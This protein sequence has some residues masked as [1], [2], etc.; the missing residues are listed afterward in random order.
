MSRR[1]YIELKNEHKSVLPPEFQHDDVRF[2]ES[3]VEH[4]LREFTQ[5]EDIVFDPFAGFGT[6]LLVAE[7][8]GRIPFGLE[9]DERRYD[10]IRSKLKHPQNLFHGDAR[11]LTRYHI[12][13]FD[14]SLTSPPFM[15]RHDTEDA[16][17]AYSLP[18]KGYRAYLKDIRSIYQQVGRMMKPEAHCVIEVSNLKQA[19]GVTPLA[20]DI[21]TEVSQVLRFEG[22]VVVCWDKYGYGYEHSYCL[23]FRKRA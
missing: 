13:A 14:L 22:E 20:W 8:M 18:G 3:L 23:I 5:E 10:Y 19:G 17:A 11:Q 1:S 4:F 21:A 12:P 15:N 7:A 6:T 9:L 2:S 16:L